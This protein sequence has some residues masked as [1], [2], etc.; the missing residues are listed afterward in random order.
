MKNSIVTA[1][2]IEFKKA[3]PL[4]QFESHQKLKEEKKMKNIPL[5]ARGRIRSII[6]CNQWHRFFPL[7]LFLFA[8]NVLMGSFDNH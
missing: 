7:F 3:F 6:D 1:N 8:S 2:G 5:R 4:H